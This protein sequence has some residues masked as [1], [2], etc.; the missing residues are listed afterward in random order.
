VKIV[1]NGQLRETPEATTVA[2]LLEQLNLSSR[3][4]AVEVNC[5]VVPRG[6]HAD[7]VLSDGDQLE[8]VTFVGGG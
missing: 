6:R 5:E 3:H 7:Y 2:D 4:V 8:V 1:F